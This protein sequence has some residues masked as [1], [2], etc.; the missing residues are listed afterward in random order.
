MPVVDRI[1]GV[2]RV[3]VVVG[4]TFVWYGLPAQSWV[5]TCILAGLVFTWIEG[6][7]TLAIGT[8]LAFVA[9]MVVWVRTGHA[10]G[11]TVTALVFRVALVA[12]AATVVETARRIRHP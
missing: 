6:W 5:S 9:G 4:G 1:V 10:F 11:D 2:V 12:V 7:L 3:L 8:A